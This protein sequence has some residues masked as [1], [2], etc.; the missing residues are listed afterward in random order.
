MKILIFIILLILTSCYEPIDGCLDRNATNFDVSADFP[1]SGDECC[2]YPRLALRATAFWGDEFMRFDTV[3]EDGAG[4]EFQLVRFRMYLTEIELPI[5]GAAPLVPLDS[6]EMRVVNSPGDTITQTLNSNLVLFDQMGGTASLQSVGN[7]T[8]TFEPSEL[9]FRLG[10]R[11]PYRSV[12]PES[13][14][15]NHPLARQEGL[16]NFSDGNGY[17]LAKIEY[18]LPDVFPGSTLTFNLYGDLPQSLELPPFGPIS[19]G[20]NVF[21]ELDIDHKELFE[22]VDLA[23]SSTLANALLLALPQVVSISSIEEG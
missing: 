15:S 19:R 6:V 10:M 20:N 21:I 23:D 7:F 1:C 17:I 11:D 16:L 12:V 8:E 18:Q 14:P 2:T 9:D 3:Y 22:N 5:T 4:N 13:L